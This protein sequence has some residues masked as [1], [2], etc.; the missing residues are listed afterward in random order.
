M[1][2]LWDPVVSIELLR[3]L[4]LIHSHIH[5]CT[6]IL[7][8]LNSRAHL[9]FQAWPRQWS[10]NHEHDVLDCL[11]S[12][13]GGTISYFAVLHSRA[14]LTQGSTWVEAV[15]SKTVLCCRKILTKAGKL[16][17]RDSG[18]VN[19]DFFYHAKSHSLIVDVCVSYTCTQ[20][21]QIYIK[22][23]NIANMIQKH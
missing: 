16:C 17:H 18:I 3:A 5:G 14:S 2:H 8:T 19:T 13:G 23:L 10:E 7:Q 9:C 15:Y 6:P 4:L 22:W 21:S 12:A 20:H 1:G 11:H